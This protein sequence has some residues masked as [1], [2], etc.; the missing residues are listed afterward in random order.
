MKTA[1]PTKILH[2][3]RLC[4]ERNEV[5]GALPLLDAIL[6]DNPDHPEALHLRGRCRL[7][8]G[9][10]EAA[11]QDYRHLAA[12][13]SAE[14][15]VRVAEARLL[16]GQ[17]QSA[18]QDFNRFL[19]RDPQEGEP[20]FLAALAGYRTGLIERSV[21]RLRQAIERGF[22]WQEESTVDAVVHHCLAGAFFLDFEQLY[23]DVFEASE[24]NRNPQNR[25]YSLNMPIYDLYTAKS[26]AEQ[27]QR[28]EQLARLLLPDEQKFEPARHVRRL[29]EM[30]RDFM[31][32]E[33]DARFG[34]EANKLL[35][36]GQ[37]HDLARLILAMLL[38]H[39]QQFSNWLGFEKER[40]HNSQ[41]QDLAP[42]L[43][44]R[45]ALV[46]LFLYAGAASDRFHAQIHQQEIEPN[47]FKAL[48]GVGFFAFYQEI[49]AMRP[50]TD[51]PA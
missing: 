46:I 29:N 44:L 13:A 4:T 31:R 18:L 20:L 39:L 33:T 34:L 5:S 9:N 3:A 35:Q 14:A 25:W 10:R 28:A 37:L 11:L 17:P 45:L 23:L 21:E 8:S 40:I 49:E 26:A 36:E 47:L 41:L 7:V 50:S 24:G 16:L 30:I 1:D 43:P 15:D 32:S 19:Q 12:Q 48:L 27:Q 2:Q 51:S 22:D 38:D 6:A 42:L